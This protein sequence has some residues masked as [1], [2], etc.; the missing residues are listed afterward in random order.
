M[1]FLVFLFSTPIPMKTEK[2]PETNKETKKQWYKTWRWVIVVFMLFPILVP[3]LVWKKTT[4]KNRIKK[5]I[6]IITT[7]LGLFGLLI[8][9][10][11]KTWMADKQKQKE[12]IEFIKEGEILLQKWN[13]SKG[14]EKIK[15]G[16]SKYKT[17]END[18]KELKEQL[19]IYDTIKKYEQINIKTILTDMSEE[20]FKKLQEWTLEK[21]YIK[22]PILNKEIIKK[23]QKNKEKRKEYIKEKQEKEKREKEQKEKEEVERKKRERT[24]KIEKQFSAR[25]GSHRNL[26]KMIKK[27]MNDPSSYEHEETVYRDM[28]KHL[29]V[30]TT[31]RWKN[32]FG[33]VVKNTVKAK[34][35]LDGDIIEIIE[36][37]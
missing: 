29:I 23:L 19:K 17:K 24:Q 30:R 15:Q 10:W 21:N 9:V 12:A 27:S 6:T 22:H 36:Q 16:E 1:S 14:I 13:I 35:S 8:I 11:I 3:Y 20:E 37:F 26:E 28:K 25:D 18:T 31:F 7:I 4:R 2:T 33:W 32:A 5:T 34:V